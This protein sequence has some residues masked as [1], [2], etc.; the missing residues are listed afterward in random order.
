M[1]GRE[2]ADGDFNC[3]QQPARQQAT[4]PASARHYKDYLG[5]VFYCGSRF[6]LLILVGFT[7][8]DR[9]RPRTR[10]SICSSTVEMPSNPNAKLYEE[11]FSLADTGEAAAC[12]LLPTRRQ[13]DGESAAAQQTISY[14]SRLSNPLPPFPCI[15]PNGWS[16]LLSAANPSVNPVKRWLGHER[17]G[18]PGHLRGGPG[19]PRYGVAC[20]LL[21]LSL[22]RRVYCPL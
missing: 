1:S 19:S 15:S 22:H 5:F 3:A 20:P 10:R 11:W 16:A 4:E 8:S 2:R 6:Y 18:G 7:C 17:A 12:A 21:P 13:G 14:S 9:P